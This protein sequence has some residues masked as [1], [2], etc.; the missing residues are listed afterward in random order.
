MKKRSMLVAVTALAAVAALGVVSAGR[1]VSGAG[2]LP[3]CGG[4]Q[5][6]QTA[7]VNCTNSKTFTFGNVQR[8]VTVVLDAK[9]DGSATATFTLD[10]VVPQEFKLRVRSHVGISSSPQPLTDDQSGTFPANSLGPVAIPFVFDCGQ[11]DMKAV[12]V[13]E[14]D[15][16]GRVGAPYVCKPIVVTTTMVA[17]TTVPATTVPGQTT[18]TVTPTTA[19]SRVLAGTI[20]ATE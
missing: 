7:P 17:P 18:T 15:S 6:I 1:H 8:T 14:G 9:A 12:Y 11:I 20:P 5:T 3:L 19:A 4:N 2:S 13:A 16:R 10:K